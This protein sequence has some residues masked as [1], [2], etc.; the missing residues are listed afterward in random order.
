MT[1]C[2]SSL[3]FVFRYTQRTI[4][5]FNSNL[6]APGML[7]TNALQIDQW[8]VPQRVDELIIQSGNKSGRIYI[9][10]KM[11]IN[12]RYGFAH[13]TTAQ[14]SWHVQMWGLVRSSESYSNPKVYIYEISRMS[15]YTLYAMGP[16]L[17][18]IQ[19]TWPSSCWQ[20]HVIKGYF[21][22]VKEVV[23]KLAWL[24]RVIDK[25]W[26]YYLF[27]GEIKCDFRLVICKI[28]R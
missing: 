20:W 24:I 3:F 7:T 25:C 28:C 16:R 21:S 8:P 18:Y 10:G 26:R 5:S 22:A 11:L 27:S 15:S 1:R 2:W 13:G 17:V 23:P 14:L 4:R 9:S 6:V 19:T 12:S